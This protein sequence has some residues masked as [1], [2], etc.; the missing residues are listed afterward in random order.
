VAALLTRPDW[1]RSLLDEVDTGTVQLAELTLE[2]KQALAA[3]PDQRLR[4]R[5]IALLRRGNA[6]PNAD[7]Q[8][9]IDEFVAVTKEKGDVAA[10]KA[11]LKTHCLKCHF[12]TTEGE[13]IGPDLTGMAVHPKE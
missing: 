13:R 6:L 12:H 2:Q 1:T 4:G 10:G 5:A 8:K 7:R 9:V 11:V 3:H